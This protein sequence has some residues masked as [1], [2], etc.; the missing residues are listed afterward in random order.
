[1]YYIV[2]SSEAGSFEPTYVCNRL[3]PELSQAFE[4]RFCVTCPC[5]KRLEII[6]KSIIHYQCCTHIMIIKDS[7]IMKPRSA[8]I[9]FIIF[10]NL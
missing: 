8:A 3:T 7:W 6:L 1:M 9:I 4:V 2:V 5:K 10:E